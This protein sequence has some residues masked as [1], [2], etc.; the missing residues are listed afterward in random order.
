MWENRTEIV[1][2]TAAENDDAFG[3]RACQ[4]LDHGECARKPQAVGSTA[5][6]C[7]S[8]NLTEITIV[9]VHELKLSCGLAVFWA[10]QD[11][12][13]S[14]VTEVSLEQRTA[15]IKTAVV[16]VLFDEEP[17][18]LDEIE[19]EGLVEIAIGGNL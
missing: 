3:L 13:T 11:G 18:V 5:L 15:M 12:Q 6:V 1:R 17:N 4:C 14:A 16:S 19:V 9:G 2:R 10:V 7:L 8:T